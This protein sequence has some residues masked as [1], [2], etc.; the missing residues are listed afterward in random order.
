MYEN[1]IE[2]QSVNF[3][4]ITVKSTCV[5]NG[6]KW[7]YLDEKGIHFIHDGIEE[8]S[9]ISLDFHNID[10][11]TMILEPIHKKV[12]TIVFSLHGGPESYEFNELRYSGIYR[13]ALKLDMAVCVLNYSGSAYQSYN[14]R[15]SAWKNWD[16]VL[17]EILNTIKFYQKHY[18]LESS[19]IIILGD[20]FGATL[21]LLTA[22]ESKDN[23]KKSYCNCT[24]KNLENHLKKVNFKEERWFKKRFSV[25]EIKI[26]FNWNNFASKINTDT[27]IIQGT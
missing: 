16:N 17:K 24:N 19:N 7:G 14:K 4:Y 12:H 21:A 15:K 23:F 2:L 9:N 26:L 25:K 20:S 10:F 27:Y 18:A 22:S 6:V 1:Y 3:N 8:K 5:V 11:P 13:E